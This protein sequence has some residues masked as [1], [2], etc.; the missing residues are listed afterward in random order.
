MKKIDDIEIPLDCE[1]ALA[2]IDH[3]D[4]RIRKRVDWI[5]DETIE[6]AQKLVKSRILYDFLKIKTRKERYLVLE[7]NKVFESA[8]L[9]D[10][11]RCASEVVIYIATIG[12]E[13]EVRASEHF[14]KGEYLKGWVLDNLGIYALR[15]TTRYLKGLIEAGRKYPVSRFSPGYNYWD[16]SQQKILFNILPSREIGVELTPYLMMKPKKSVSGIM[17][18]TEKNFDGCM[19]C[20]RFDCEYRRAEYEKDHS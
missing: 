9:V 11:L 18:H 4:P 17:G 12:S 10:K 7:N 19:I 5:V 3:G 1:E 20:E 15:A 13:L 8:I 2:L 14:A 16:I 6:E